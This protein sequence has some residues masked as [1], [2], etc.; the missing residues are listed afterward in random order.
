LKGNWIFGENF[1]LRLRSRR[2]NRARNQQEAGN[3]QILILM[4]PV[5]YQR[6]ARRYIPEDTTLYNHGCENHSLA[7]YRSRLKRFSQIQPII[8][9]L[10]KLCRN[11]RA[12]NHVRIRDETPTSWQIFFVVCIGT[13]RRIPRKCLKWMHCRFLSDPFQLIVPYRPIND[14]CVVRVTDSVA[15]KLQNTNTKTMPQAQLELVS[16]MSA[17]VIVG[18][19]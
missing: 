19:L 12:T 8:W 13:S 5:D 16:L 7:F 2:I 17:T 1:R 3:K 15:T 6:N 18:R 14:R 11:I 4:K 9:T 10:L